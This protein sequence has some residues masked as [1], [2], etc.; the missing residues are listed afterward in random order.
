MV[1]QEI[2]QGTGN[3]NQI[4]SFCTQPVNSAQSNQ[5]HLVVEAKARHNNTDIKKGHSCQTLL[6]K[7]INDILLGIDKFA[8]VL[9]LLDFSAAFDAVNISI[10]FN[11]LQSHIGFRGIAYK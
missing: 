1:V 10:L 4:R 9:L 6:V 11:I 2:T 8:S 3:N 7:L 5:I